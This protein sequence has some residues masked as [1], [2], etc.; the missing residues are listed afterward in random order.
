MTAP[1]DVLLCVGVFCVIGVA[2]RHLLGSTRVPYTVAL[3]ILSIAIGCLGAKIDPDLLLAV[4]LPPLLFE[5]SFSMEVQQIKKCM[6]QMLLLAGPGVIISTFCIGSALKLTLPYEWSWQTSLL[7]GA[8][9]SA[10]D[11][12]AVVALLKDLR[13]SKKM[14]TIIEGESMMNDGASI[15]VYRLFY[16]MMLGKHFNWEAIG[17]YL[18]IATSGALGIGIAFGIATILCLD[19]VFN[20]PMINLSL[21]L[22]GSYIAY[23]VAQEGADVSGIL[24]VVS[25]GMFMAVVARTTFT[26]HAR[27]S[28][29]HSWE[30][31]AYIANT[32]IFILSGIIMAEGII[33]SDNLDRSGS[34]WAYLVLVYVIVQ[35]TRVIIVVLLYPALQYFGYGL[36]CKEATLL[37][38]SGLRGAV[39]LAMALSVKNASRDS[40]ALTSETGSLILFFTVGTVFLTLVVNGSTAQFLLSLLGMDEL[41]HVEKLV[42]D[43]AKY[44][45]R[46]KYLQAQEILH[47]QDCDLESINHLSVEN[48]MQPPTFSSSHKSL[49]QLNLL[50]TREHLLN[51]VRAAY[52]RM[53]DD[54]SLSGV[55]A[56]FLMSSVDEA[57]DA[58]PQEPLCDWRSLK[59]FIDFR[60]CDKVFNM[61]I[62]PRWLVTFL[63]MKRLQFACYICVA[64]LRAHRSARRKLG[65]FM[66]ETEI[67]SI[68]LNESEAE[69]REAAKLLEEICL[70]FPQVLGSVRMTQVVCSMLHVLKDYIQNLEVEGL[71][72]EKLGI[73]LHDLL[74]SGFKKPYDNTLLAKIPRM[75][76]VVNAHP[77]LGRLPSEVRHALEGSMKQVIKPRDTILCEEGSMPK[78][79][80][81]IQ[82][83]LLKCEIK[84]SNS[85]RSVMRTPAEELVLGLYE[86]LSG[87]P[88]IYEISTDSFALCYVLE[89]K[90]LLPLLMHNPSLE[91]LFWQESVIVLAKLLL[92]EVLE[93]LTMQGF[94]A[95]ITERFSMSTHAGGETMV[96]PENSIVF[97]LGGVLTNQEL[98]G[99]VIEPPAVLLA[100]HQSLASSS[101]EIPAPW[102]SGFCHYGYQYQVETIARTAYIDTLGWSP[103]SSASS[104]TYGGGNMALV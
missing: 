14:S 41:S 91:N 18:T 25:F 51:A 82:N 88:C 83:G 19:F 7:L 71:L 56:S 26:S 43:Y 98:P 103:G 24:T 49:D 93:K 79:L 104:L 35:L 63:A 50:A 57:T 15:V 92:P 64:F 48:F 33:N 10:T 101:S 94:R 68:V 45:L 20:D 87:K 1:T 12:V 75:R 29:N 13:T 99:V 61:G 77:L 36:N 58:V 102:R 67:V 100:S 95:L 76:D 27:R 9:L 17:K 90:T 72:E 96:I 78:S 30:F 65:D 11:P 62:F 74:M 3:L 80:W 69:E 32:L 31:I 6:V 2:C 5:G 52:W 85:S 44:K 22:A 42:L 28:L 55:P 73:I 39:G 66:G 40:L 23:F 84:N 37:V 46:N 8:V 38:W 86:I 16:N 81:L 89:A 97:L 34:S 53:L 21:T 70:A 59:V 54:G 47:L 4:F 60:T